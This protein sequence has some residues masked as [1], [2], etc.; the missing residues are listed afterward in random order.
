MSL[1]PWLALGRL[2]M[3]AGRSRM[4]VRAL[5]MPGYAVMNLSA[6]RLLPL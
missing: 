5:Q 6:L 4:V 3:P 1:T 2:R